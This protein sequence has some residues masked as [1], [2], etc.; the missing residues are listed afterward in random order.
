MLIFTIARYPGFVRVD[1]VAL[2]SIA[3][4]ELKKSLGDFFKR[5]SWPIPEPDMKQ[6]CPICAGTCPPVDVVDFNKS[7]EELRGKFLP[8]SGIPI[9]YL[10]CE[11]C[12]F[13]FAPEF[14]S[15]RLEDFENNIYNSEY[16]Q[17][18]PDYLDSRPRANA[19]GL[20]SLFGE[21]GTEIRHLDYGGGGGLLS[22]ILRQSGWRSTSYDPFVDRG[23]LPGDLGKFD[24]ITAYEVFEHVPEVE[25]LMA[26]LTSLLA[27]GGIVLF[28]TL[29]SDGNI[30]SRQRLSWWYASP[31]NGHISLFSRQSLAI[32]AAKKGFNFGSFTPG[33]HA[34]WRT[35]PAW[36]EHIFRAG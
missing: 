34:F 27:E 13:C 29:L 14:A 19:S 35:V 24:L 23:L 2:A 30:A 6:P 5:L 20:A 18:D 21:R 3:E 1:N 17:V 22:E 8:L 12:G 9:Y 31:R 26:D 4:S 32:L 15:W 7:C 36:A 33:F 10:L 25:R 28:S 11:H 16:V